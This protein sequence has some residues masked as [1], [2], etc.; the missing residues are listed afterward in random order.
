MHRGEQ[1]V[2]AFGHRPREAGRRALACR[3]QGE[4]RFVQAL[5]G[6]QRITATHLEAHLRRRQPLQRLGD[7]AIGG[8]IGVQRDRA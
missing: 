6:R 1:I 8:C 7:R 5:C 4:R 2:I 3:E